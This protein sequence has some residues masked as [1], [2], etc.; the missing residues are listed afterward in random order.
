M[1][2]LRG[3]GQR[4]HLI[5]FSSLLPVTDEESKVNNIEMHQHKQAN[6]WRQGQTAAIVPKCLLR[7]FSFQIKH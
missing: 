4:A 6:E 3:R 7:T 1:D 5:S 2:E